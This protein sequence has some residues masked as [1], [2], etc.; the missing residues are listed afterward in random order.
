MTSSRQG[1]NLRSTFPTCSRRTG[2]SIDCKDTSPCFALAYCNDLLNIPPL[3]GTETERSQVTLLSLF[4]T[5]M[6]NSK[7]TEVSVGSKQAYRFR[8]VIPFRT[9]KGNFTKRNKRTLS[10]SSGGMLELTS[11]GWEILSRKMKWRETEDDTLHRCL[12]ST[13]TLRDTQTHTY[14]HSY[15]HEQANRSITK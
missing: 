8:E 6:P 2:G 11:P 4:C 5:K 10:V 1:I 7:A 3:K 13:Y 12:A 9:F 14:V 15:I